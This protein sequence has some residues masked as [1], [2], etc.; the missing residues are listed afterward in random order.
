[1][2]A[3]FLTDKKQFSVTELQVNYRAFLPM[4]NKEKNRYET[5]VF[6]IDDLTSVAIE[7]LATNHILPFRSP[8]FGYGKCLSAHIKTIVIAELPHLNLTVEPDDQPIRH[9]C[10]IGWSNIKDENKAL[11]QR[12]GTCA[13]L[14]PFSTPLR[15]ANLNPR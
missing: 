10:I 8:I 11:A 7:E 4:L 14:I 9:A 6:F 2:I 1:V 3:R 12:L 15:N 5:S 13:E